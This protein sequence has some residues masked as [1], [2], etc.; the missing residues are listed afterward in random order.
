MVRGRADGDA[1]GQR[2]HIEVYVAPEVAEL[3]LA[4]AIAAGGTVV[5][6]SEAPSLTVIADHDGNTGVLAVAAAATATS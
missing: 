4:A 6:D 5:D 1:P 2:F 3:R